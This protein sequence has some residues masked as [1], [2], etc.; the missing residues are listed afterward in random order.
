MTFKDPDLAELDRIWPLG[1]QLVVPD[2]GTI[3]VAGAYEGRYMRYLRERFPTADIWGYEPQESKGFKDP[4]LCGYGLAT[5]NRTMMVSWVGT[6]GATLVGKPTPNQQPVRVWDA[7]EVV[8][9]RNPEVSLAIFNMEGSEWAVLPYLL[10]EMMHH[11]I[12]SMAIQF[13]PKYVSEGRANRVLSY[14]DEYYDRKYWDYPTWT[15]WVRR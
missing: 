15:H 8:A 3:V 11:R 2:K 13:H 1:Q 12:A 14:L 4:K 7:V 5:N 10:D 6:D 9:L